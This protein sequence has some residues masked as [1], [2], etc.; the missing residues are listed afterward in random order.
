MPR[1]RDCQQQNKRTFRIVGFA[2]PADHR[3]KLKQL[4]RKISTLNFVRAEKK[5]WNMKVKLVPI[6]VGA[7]SI[8]TNGLITVLEDLEIRG[9]VEIIQT[10]VFL[11]RPE[12]YRESGRLANSSE[13]PLANAG[14]KN[15]QNSEIVIIR[16]K[17][18]I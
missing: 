7:L 6:V 8:I 9:Q 1:T 14:V 12:Y 2:V 15:S 10:T 17:L 3:V 4:K 13:K 5:L 11:D 16:A 18:C